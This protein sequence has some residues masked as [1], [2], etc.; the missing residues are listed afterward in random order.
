MD[1]IKTKIHKT[2]SILENE[3]EK[4]SED[5]FLKFC[6]T[7]K[8]NILNAFEKENLTKDETKLLLGRVNTLLIQLEDHKKETVKRKAT[9]QKYREST[10]IKVCP[11]CNARNRIHANFCKKCGYKLE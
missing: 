8:R 10:K 2:L 4:F 7:V 5:K 3:K 11:G 1:D 6:K 9:T